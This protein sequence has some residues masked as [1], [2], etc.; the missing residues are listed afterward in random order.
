MNFSLCIVAD[1]LKKE[2]NKNYSV[3]I[4]IECISARFF[5]PLV[6]AT[7]MIEMETEIFCTETEWESRLYCEYHN[8]NQL[9]TSTD[10]NFDMRELF[11]ERKIRKKN[12]MAF[13]IK[14]IYVCNKLEFI[15]QSFLSVRNGNVRYLFTIFPPLPFQKLCTSMEKLIKYF[16]TRSSFFSCGTEKKFYHLICKCQAEFNFILQ[17]MPSFSTI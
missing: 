16:C 8:N 15:K 12:T 13:K 9:K 3:P 6:V 4:F 1:K 14:A 17:E 5:P 7:M 10:M 11:Q 2:K